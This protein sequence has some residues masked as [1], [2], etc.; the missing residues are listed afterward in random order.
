MV[1]VRGT[2]GSEGGVYSRVATASW[3]LDSIHFSALLKLAADKR[4]DTLQSIFAY[5]LEDALDVLHG[6]LVESEH[7]RP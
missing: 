3:L 2:K 6:L 1:S 5:W 7:D 4:E